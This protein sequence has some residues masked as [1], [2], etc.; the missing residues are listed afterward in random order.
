RAASNGRIGP[1]SEG[2]GEGGLRR[3]GLFGGSFDPVHVGHLHA[4]R[5]ARDAFGLQRVLFVPAARPPHK[6]GRT[7]A[8]AHHRRAMLELALAEEPAFV[9]D[10]L[11]LSRAGPSYSIDTVAEIEAREGGPEAV[12]LF[13]VLGSD[14]LAGLESWRSVE[15]LLQRVRPVVVGRGSDLRSRFDRLRAKLGSRLV[16]RLEDGLLD[17]PPV[18]AAATDLRE[19]L[20]CGD[21]S[22]G[23][24]DPRVLEYARAHDLY[25]EAP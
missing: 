8:A 10:P 3:L 7:L 5:A 4:A 20:A 16:S 23:L 1:V 22:G 21:A 6:P 18:D 9:V 25:A 17:L 24:L 11:E 19:R 2:A 12:E 14:N 13:W 15:E